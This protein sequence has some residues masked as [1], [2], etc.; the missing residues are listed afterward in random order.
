MGM[1]LGGLASAG[2]GLIDSAMGNI[3]GLVNTFNRGLVGHGF[4][5]Q[6]AP[7]INDV[8]GHAR[9]VGRWAEGF[10][11]DVYNERAQAFRDNMSG[12]GDARAGNGV[13]GQATREG[14]AQDR[15]AMQGAVDYADR[16][17]SPLLEHANDTY[18]TAQ[19]QYAETKAKMAGATTDA[20]A[21]AKE[22]LRR[23]MA[24]G[25]GVL[26]GITDQVA[27]GMVG[28][29]SR[30]EAVNQDTE[31]QATAAEA[32]GRP[33]MAASIRKR[34]A[35]ASAKEM[36]DQSS[37]LRVMQ[38]QMMTDARQKNMAMYQDANNTVVDTIAKTAGLE[39]GANATSVRNLIDAVATGNQA[40]SL[41][42]QG[43]LATRIQQAT[44]GRTFARDLSSAIS[45]DEQDVENHAINIDNQIGSNA[46]QYM[47]TVI[48][49][50]NTSLSALAALIQGHGAVAQILSGVQFN[51]TPGVG[52][53]VND[54]LQI[55]AANAEP[56]GPSGFDQAMGAVGTGAMT[57]MGVGSFM[58]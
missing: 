41:A 30:L 10:G 52:Q 49:G 57:A 15:T 27:T 9:D 4:Q 47:S 33:D 18:K 43:P 31:T 56:P 16:T 42:I 37:K 24:L 39:A 28:L 5:E 6:V 54:Y 1:D 35:F 13:R 25:E 26:A 21:T 44:M 7:A 12:Y 48:T 22:G 46:N 2:G 14:Y 19:D 58:H 36:G 17:V 32:A 20:V 50:V 55:Q 38:S 45:M 53:A 23:T 8:T 51:Y 29:G 40:A 11:N 3:T 34:G